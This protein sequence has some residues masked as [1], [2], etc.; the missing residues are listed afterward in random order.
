MLLSGRPALAQP[1]PERWAL[2]KQAS[3]RKVY[4][5]SCYMMS[6][7]IIVYYVL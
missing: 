4:I 6:W 7:Y 3:R 5:I 2:A 1:A